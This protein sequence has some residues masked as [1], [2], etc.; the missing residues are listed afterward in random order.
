MSSLELYKSHDIC[1]PSKTSLYVRWNLQPLP[2]PIYSL[3]VSAEVPGK[4]FSP[5]PECSRIHKITMEIKEAD[6]GHHQGTLRLLT[7][8]NV[9]TS[10]KV[11]LRLSDS[12][13]SEVRLIIIKDRVE[14]ANGIGALKNDSGSDNFLN[15]QGIFFKIQK[16]CWLSSWKN[17]RYWARF[18]IHT[19]KGM[20]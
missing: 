12:T 3:K 5:L 2:L 13:R 18:R 9:I 16:G 15:K 4:S 17:L 8:L 19:S 7:G 20:F 6:R 14:E 10:A 1:H 11:N